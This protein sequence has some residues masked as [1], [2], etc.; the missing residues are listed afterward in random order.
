[1]DSRLARKFMSRELSS[2]LAWVLVVDKT[3]ER[4]ANLEVGAASSKHPVPFDAA[5]EG[6][7]FGPCGPGVR[8]P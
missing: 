6:N 1:M 5:R 7:R 8:W 4:R 3:H 2:P